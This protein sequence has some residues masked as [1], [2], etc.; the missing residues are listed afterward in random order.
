[1]H[2]RHAT[3][4][5]LGKLALLIERAYRGATARR[6]W[7]HEADLLGGSR[8]APGELER[9]LADPAQT[10]L[11]A[12]D[13]G[14]AVGCVLVVD[15]GHDAYLG[16]LTVDPDRQSAGL[17]SRLLA[18]AEAHARTLGRATIAMRVLAPR[19]ELVAWYARAGWRETG[20]REPF[21]HPERTAHDFRVLEKSVV[22]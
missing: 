20:R 17:G 22:D 18:A 14:A 12:F 4:S 16:L 13:G 7:T 21:P 9:V 15:R 1:M 8:L 3:V 6:G 11:G 2:I 5:D 19:D 10:L